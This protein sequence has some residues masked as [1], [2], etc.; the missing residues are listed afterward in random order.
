[1]SL[2]LSKNISYS[3]SIPQ[4][5]LVQKDKDKA[6]NG[7]TRNMPFLLIRSFSFHFNAC[8]VLTTPIKC[9]LQETIKSNQKRTMIIF[10]ICLYGN[11]DN[12]WVI[13]QETHI[14]FL[15]PLYSLW[16]RSFNSSAVCSR[17]HNCQ[18]KQLGHNF[19][20]K[21]YKI[22]QNPLFSLWH[23]CHVNKVAYYI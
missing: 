12:R 1:M 8:L 2:H 3:I 17:E 7:K 4:G 9:S 18:R 23:Q 20:L 6:K 10:F 11:T 15:H 14:N 22:K 19:L 21:R 5:S 16:Q 13:L